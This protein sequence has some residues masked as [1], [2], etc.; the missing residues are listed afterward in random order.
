M[1]KALLVTALLIAAFGAAAEEPKPQAEQQANAVV[2][3]L[4]VF[5]AV[6]NYLAT[7]PYAEVAGLLEGMQRNAPVSVQQEPQNEPKGEQP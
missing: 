1:K 7:K 2:I 5:R 4:P 3:E 6:V